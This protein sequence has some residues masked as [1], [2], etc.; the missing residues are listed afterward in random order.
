MDYPGLGSRK[1]K[2]GPEDIDEEVM[3]VDESLFPDHYANVVRM[4]IEIE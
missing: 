2:V 1:S 3:I 4:M